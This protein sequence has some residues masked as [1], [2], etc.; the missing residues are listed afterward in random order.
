MTMDAFV[1]SDRALLSMH[2]W[3]AAIDAEGFRLHPMR[4]GPSER[5]AATYPPGGATGTPGSNVAMASSRTSRR[6]IPTSISVAIGSTS[7][8][9]TGVRL[10]VALAPTSPE[11]ATR[12]PREA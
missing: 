2:E 9:C 12:A 7:S 11:P 10:R 4:R 5:S 6:L 1:L 3:Q 8:A